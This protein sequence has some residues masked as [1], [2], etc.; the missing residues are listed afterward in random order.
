MLGAT[1]ARTQRESDIL[2]VLRHVGG[3]KGA[4]RSGQAPHHHSRRAKIEAEG[5]NNN[6]NSAGRTHQGGISE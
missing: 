6:N 1:D 5:N 4:V 3:H 2:F